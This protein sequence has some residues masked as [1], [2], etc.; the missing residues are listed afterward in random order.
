MEIVAGWLF[1]NLER[2]RM[3]FVADEL[4]VEDGIDWDLLL[5]DDYLQRFVKH[6]KACPTSEGPL[7]GYRIDAPRAVVHKWLQDHMRDARELA[8]NTE[9][10]QP[11]AGS[12]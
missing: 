5:K 4:H 8:P 2:T 3:V 1:L 7:Q 12:Q 10:S 11:S 9:A 6:F